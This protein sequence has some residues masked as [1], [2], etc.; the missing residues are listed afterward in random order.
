MLQLLKIQGLFP[1]ILQ[2]GFSAYK[3][4][5]GVSDDA[6]VTNW[7]V[8]SPSFASSN[9][10]AVSGVYTVPVTGVYATEAT[11]SYVT[12]SAI[13]TQ[14]GTSISPSFTI[15]KTDS[16]SGLVVGM[17]P[18]FY[19]SLLVLSLRTILASGTVTLS[20]VVQLTKG[21][22][23]GLYYNADGLSLALTLEEVRWAAFR[24]K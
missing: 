19:T 8:A 18:I 5:F 6:M 23:L 9:F 24:L 7:S 14:L 13:T 15:K 10:G 22:T 11:I 3:A 1:D 20:G 21:D 16:T 12:D 17:F 2:E 4:S